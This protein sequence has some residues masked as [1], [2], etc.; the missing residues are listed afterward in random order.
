MIP[1]P[2]YVVI[3]T[4]VFISAFLSHN[5]ESPV[6]S[7][8]KWIDDELLIPIY[9]KETMAEYKEVAQRKKFGLDKEKVN[10]FFEKSHQLGLK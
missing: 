2:F 6:M 10:R 4:N 3:D 5:R 9:S 7:I 1:L 8:V